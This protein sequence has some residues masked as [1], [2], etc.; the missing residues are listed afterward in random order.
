[1][2]P[3][4]IDFLIRSLG[5]GGAERQL[6][7]LASGLARRGH[8]VRILTLYPGGPFEAEALARGLEIHCLHKR[9][10]WDV[11]PFLYRLHRVWRARSPQLIHSYMSSSNV[12][13]V[14]LKPLHHHPVVWGLRAS[15]IDLSHYDWLAGA[16]GWLE[17]HLAPFAD[18]IITNS[19]AGRRHASSVGF[20]GSAL[21]VIDNGFE[22]DMWRRDPGAGR[23]FRMELG[24]PPDAPL[25]GM[26][27]RLDPLKG[28][29]VFLQA[30]ARL[31]E[32]RPDVHFV[33]VGPGPVTA[34]HELEAHAH[35]LCAQLP[36]HWADGQADMI[37]VYSALDSIVSASFSEGFP[38]V[39]AEA[40]ACGLRP[41][42]TDVG[43]SRRIVGPC[44]WVVPPGNVND[45]AA[46]MA[47]A[48]SSASAEGPEPA[49]HIRATFDVEHLIERTE[50]L[51]GEM[52]PETP[53]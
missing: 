22:C 29:K 3:L 20:P 38:N 33:A 49:A 28:H 8:Q 47:R 4:V 18:L 1:M 32:S 9:G 16:S 40:M 10:R 11:V 42:V 36:L 25:I 30:A 21:R 37:P 52:L 13:A 50:V 34:K 24:I 35:Q 31:H 23:R 46:A 17:A 19:E 53:S 39:I 6:V 2:R 43:D 41:V 48:V 44:G 45:M 15:N 5:Q 27:A 14:V 12:I 7:L 51:L 26:V